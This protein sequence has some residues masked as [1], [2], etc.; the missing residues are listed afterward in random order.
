[1]PMGTPGRTRSRHAPWSSGLRRSCLR[2][3]SAIPPD[4]PACEH[5]NTGR[6]R[7]LPAP[8]RPD[9][10]RTRSRVGGFVIGCGWNRPTATTESRSTVA[11]PN[12][13]RAQ[14]QQ[15]A[16]LLD[17][18]SYT[19]ELD[20]TDGG[21]KPGDTTFRSTT[22]VRFGCTTPGESSWIDLVAAGVTRAVLN[23][24]E[25]DVSGYREDDGIALPDLAES[26]E[27]LV[28]AQCRYMNTG[29]GLHRFV[30]PLD[31]NVYLYS[32]FETADAKRVF[33]CFDQ[34][35]L[36][37]RYRFTVQAPEGWTVISNGSEVARTP[38]GDGA[39]TWEF[40]E[41]ERISS[42]LTALVAGA[43]HRAEFGYASTSGEVPG[44]IVC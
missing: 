6:P 38:T 18:D 35:D 26:N 16:E 10:K 4:R 33:A 12:L 11:A 41:T 37:A 25:L 29:E 42:Y 43:Y 17:V 28:Q 32:Q 19:I 1:M 2:R 39:A 9:V 31:G 5:R 40:A 21:G 8:P 23:G 13:T 14:A 15:R 24:V 27:L 36:K 22:R 3:S 34:P 20:L 7:L 30:D 44:A